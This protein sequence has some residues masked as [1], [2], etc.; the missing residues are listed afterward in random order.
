MK[1][2]DT[3]LIILSSASQREDGLAILPE[4]LK[5]RRREGG[6]DQAPR[7]GSPEGGPGEAGRA[8]LAGGRERAPDRAQA[9]ALGSERYPGRG[10][11]GRRRG[12]GPEGLQASREGA[13]RGSKGKAGSDAIPREGTKKALVLSLLSRP[14]GATI[15]DLVGATGWLPHTTRAALTGLRKKGYEFA[16]SKNAEG[17]TV[18]RTEKTPKAG[19]GCGLKRWLAWRQEQVEAEIARPHGLSLEALRARWHALWQPGTPVAPARS[20]D[21]RRC[22]PDPGEGLRR[23]IGRDEEEAARDRG[24]G[25]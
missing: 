12:A 7:P 2:T 17:E 20:A 19:E 14:Q 1:L 4:K 22:L 24:R 8:A 13:R 10:R 23:P 11:S 21:P 18:Y 6:R 9:H 16:K 15:D 25:A 3:Q 5:G